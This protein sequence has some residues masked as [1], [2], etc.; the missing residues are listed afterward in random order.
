MTN[1]SL[2]RFGVSK[3]KSNRKGSPTPMH[4]YHEEDSESGSD[5]VS[6]QHKQRG[7]ERCLSF[8]GS[9]SS[10]LPARKTIYAAVKET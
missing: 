6:G 9:M 7:N 4:K 8:A 2:I 1:E 10:A 3:L 5:L